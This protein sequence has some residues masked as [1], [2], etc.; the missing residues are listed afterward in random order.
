MFGHS[1]RYIYDI[2]PMK[3]KSL[4]VLL[5][6][7]PVLSVCAQ[8]N[9]L[10]AKQFKLHKGDTLSVH[11]LAGDQ[12]K[13][14]DEYKYDAAKTKKFMLYDSGKK[15]NLMTAAKDSAAPIYAGVAA[16]PGLVMVELVRNIPPTAI[17]REVYAKYLSDEGL[18]KLSESVNNSNQQHFREK[19]VCYLKT[20]VQVDDKATGGDF[21]K[22][23]G[24]DY[25]IVLKKNPY[26]LNYGEDVTGV[27]YLKGKPVKNA[28]L[29]VF[30][31][32]ISGNIY[33]QRVNADEKGEF[34]VTM[35]REGAY[36]IRSVITKPSTGTDVDFET[37]ETAFTFVF[38]SQN[39]SPNSFKEFGLGDL[40]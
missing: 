16:T 5:F 37:V 39:D 33:P 22:V 40:H 27:L 31:R 20:L 30:L 10:L 15:I 36:M 13:I 18:P 24:E 25:E 26:K 29:D 2:Y 9:F 7:L 11:L 38:N 12:F 19:K 28:S 6:C 35:S 21:D 1:D 4:L 23:Q 8:D 32:T 3:N 17:D 34:S 14:E